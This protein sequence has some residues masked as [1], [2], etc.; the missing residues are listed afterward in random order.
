VLKQA[1]ARYLGHRASPDT[2]CEKISG[3]WR[4]CTC[5]A[6]HAHLLHPA[7]GYD[8]HAARSRRIHGWW[9]NSPLPFKAFMQDLEAAQGRR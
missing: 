7:W 2:Y 4:G 3:M 6:G 5:R 9:G 8:T 1:P